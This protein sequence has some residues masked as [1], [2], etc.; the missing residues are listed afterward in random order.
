MVKFNWGRVNL[1]ARLES[2]GDS[3]AVDSA[4]EKTEKTSHGEELLKGCAVDGG[5]LKDTEDD[6]V[7]DHGPLASPFITSE[8]KHGCADR[9]EEESKGDGGSDGGL[10]GVIVNRELLGLDRQSMEVESIS[11]PGTESYKEKDPILARK[12][13]H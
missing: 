2:H 4:H 3:I 7:E 6:H 12:L 8:T 5:D 11:S 10:A 13:S 1:R 9:S